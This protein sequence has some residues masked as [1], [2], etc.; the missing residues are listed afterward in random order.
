MD[1]KEEGMRGSV[2]CVLVGIASAAMGGT[3]YMGS[4]GQ[5]PLSGL[6]L[7]LLVLAAIFFPLGL[8]IEFFS[9]GAYLRSITRS[10]DA[11]LSLLLA[12]RPPSPPGGQNP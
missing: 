8:L 3:F 11:I 6:G 10:A 5:Q 7:M 4:Q 12:N 2:I 9:I 1:N